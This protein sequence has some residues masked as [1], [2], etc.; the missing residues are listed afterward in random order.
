MVEANPVFNYSSYIKL[1][2]NMDDVKIN[3]Y[4]PCGY[5][6]DE[7]NS[8]GAGI[9]SK[10]NEDV[11]KKHTS[12][13]ES[14]LMTEV[15]D[16]GIYLCFPLLLD[17]STID[18]YLLDNTDIRIRLELV[19]QDWV[20]K[21][22]ERIP[23]VTL[24]I[25]KAKLWIDR[26]TPHHNAL[27][28]L[29]KAIASKPLEY[30]FNKTLYKTYVIGPGE[31]SILIDQPFGTCIPEKLTMVIVTM[32]SLSGD[33][34]LNPLYFGHCNISNIHI[35]INGT[36]IYNINTD[37][38]SGDY[39]HRFYETQKAIGIDTDNMISF[40]TYKKGRSVFCFNFLK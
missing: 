39:A 23:D 12:F 32:Q 3:R 11:F 13:I 29:N 30:I 34:T 37:F 26:V 36:L 24:N 7:Y 16:D 38:P 19:N 14:H 25:T 40:D 2:K 5:L 33:Q 1:L 9:T 15:K 6:Y 8:F 4:G 10:Y 28:A 18:M 20:I 35:T 17:I 31:S 27:L 21:S 22:H